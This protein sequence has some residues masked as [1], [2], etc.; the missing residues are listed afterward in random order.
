MRRFWA[1]FKCFL[2]EKPCKEPHRCDRPSSFFKNFQWMVV[3]ARSRDFDSPWQPWKPP[4]WTFATVNGQNSRWIRSFWALWPIPPMGFCFVEKHAFW[5]W[6]FLCS[7]QRLGHKSSCRCSHVPVD[8]PFLTFLDVTLLLTFPNVNKIS[9]L[10]WEKEVWRMTC[11]SWWWWVHVLV[12]SA[13]TVMSCRAHDEARPMW[14]IL[15]IGAKK[16]RLRT[17]SNNMC[18]GKLVQW[19]CAC[20]DDDKFGIGPKMIFTFILTKT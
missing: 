1:C 13:T 8:L 16:S 12:S 3:I 18:N 19:H 5:D 15:Q 11:W 17:T 10:W 20:G 4:F 6:F 7:L 2:W 9:K 14:K